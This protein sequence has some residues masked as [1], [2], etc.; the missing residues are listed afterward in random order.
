[1]KIATITLFFILINFTLSAKIENNDE[2][3]IQFMNLFNKYSTRDKLIVN[4]NKSVDSL[5]TTNKIKNLILKNEINENLDDKQR[6]K[7]TNKVNNNEDNDKKIIQDTNLNNNAKNYTKVKYNLINKFDSEIFLKTNEIL[8]TFNNEFR[9]GNLKGGLVET[10]N[11]YL[12]LIITTNCSY[13]LGMLLI[14][15]GFF[16]SIF[17]LFIS[18]LMSR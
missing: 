16:L 14:F 1:M 2:N 10:Q 17:A 8:R 11:K 6:F 12:D 7:D 9:Q 15:I 13:T 5:S 18:L 4:N 3:L